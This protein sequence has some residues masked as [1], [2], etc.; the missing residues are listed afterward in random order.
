MPLTSSAMVPLG[1]PLPNFTLPDVISGRPT[2][3]TALDPAKPVLVL[4]IAAHCPFSRHIAPA[5]REVARSYRSRVNLLALCANDVAQV[6]EDSPEGLRRLAKELE[7]T[8]PFCYDV[9]QG[10][11]R[12]FGATCTP[13]CFL[14]D[15]SRKLVYRGEIDESR[16][17][18]GLKGL[19]AKAPT[20]APVR[21]ALEALLNGKPMD[22]NQR[23]G[24]GCNIKWCAPARATAGHI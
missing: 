6:P 24:S 2:S 18:G 12:A 21:G 9:S 7:W 19:L 10:A 14:Y 15:T 11:A 17:A 4:F 16:P 22:P 13:E 1:T 5:I 8:D 3:A 20:G 23:P